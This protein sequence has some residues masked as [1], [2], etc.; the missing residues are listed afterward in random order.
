MSSSTVIP[1]KRFEFSAA[2]ASAPSGISAWD[3]LMRVLGTLHDSLYAV[4]KPDVLII[5]DDPVIG[6]LIALRVSSEGGTAILTPSGLCKEDWPSA[7]YGAISN[8][9][10]TCWTPE[11][12]LELSKWLGPGFREATLARAVTGLTA[13][14]ARTERVHL[15]ADAMIQTS[16]DHCRG[17]WGKKPLFPVA[18]NE[19]QGPVHP[20]W[21]FIRRDL[22]VLRFNRREMELLMPSKVILT[23]HPSKFV[24]QSSAMTKAG[25]F[26]EGRNYRDNW[27][28]E[29]LEDFRHAGLMTLQ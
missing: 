3:L 21:T 29:R 25:L 22:P 19:I 10:A 5:G 24:E 27:E 13:A 11:I 15:I 8:S 18:L 20:L 9:E 14:C 7:D 26:R 28:A 17:I 16:S 12:A 4:L 2:I 1:L 6:L 23:T